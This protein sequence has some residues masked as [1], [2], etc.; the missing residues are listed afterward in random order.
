MTSPF[1][2]ELFIYPIKSCAGIP[3]PK[4]SV[5]DRGFRLDRRWMVTD[6]DG[7]F[8]TQRSHPR[9]ALA[10]LGLESDRLSVTAD[11]MEKVLTP[12]EI[13]EGDSVEV[14]VWKSRVRA[15][16]GTRE[17]EEWF[18]TLLDQPCLVV[19]M[20]DS[21][22]RPIRPDYAKRGEHIAFS[23]AFP[24][25]L[26]S[27]ASL[28]DLNRRLV[29]P[30]PMNRFRPNIVV[31]N[32]GAYAEDNW[33]EIRIGSI[34]LTVAKPCARCATTTVDQE[35]GSKSAEPLRTLATYRNVNGDVMFGQNL[36]HR[37]SG[38]LH[39]GDPL[40]ITTVSKR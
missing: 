26:I 4:A 5:V 12:A 6:T 27:Q 9:L 30:L 24:F 28:D 21:S 11:V 15:L 25:L 40:E 35:T 37:A 16:R 8:L 38:V 31:G 14:E 17:I 20:P 18:S 13:F 7:K 19:H 34:P 36:I 39:V 3:V 23:D 22:I 29:V 33:K 2:S 10:K 32:C 1:V